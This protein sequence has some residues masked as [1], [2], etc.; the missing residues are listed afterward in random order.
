MNL[1][2]DAAPLG[3]PGCWLIVS[4]DVVT[5]LTNS[6]GAARMSFEV[7]NVPTLAGQRIYMQGLVMDRGANA[8]GLVAK[9]GARA[10]VSA[11]D[12]HIASR[13]FM[14]PRVSFKLA[15]YFGPTSDFHFVIAACI[16]FARSGNRSATFVVS[17]TSLLR[18]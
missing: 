1:P 16:A 5:G 9:S 11:S 7:P 17:W 10:S 15:R 3:M 12:N 2:L 14:S 8:L 13:P 6:S 18:S 4:F